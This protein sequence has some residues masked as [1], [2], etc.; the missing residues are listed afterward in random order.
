MAGD[1][2]AR[3]PAGRAQRCAAVLHSAHGQFFR[4]I[5]P[6][7]ARIAYL[8]LFRAAHCDQPA[9]RDG[10]EVPAGRVPSSDR[11]GAG[12]QCSGR[13]QGPAARLRAGTAAALPVSALDGGVESAAHAGGNDAPLVGSVALLLRSVAQER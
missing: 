11:Q 10:V 9:V 13:R 3:V 12:S 5:W 7:V 6:D 8:V 1:N 2:A 4:R